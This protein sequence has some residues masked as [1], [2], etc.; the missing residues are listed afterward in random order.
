MMSNRNPLCEGARRANLTVSYPNTPDI[1]MTETSQRESSNLSSF[2][3]FISK[4]V[5]SGAT[6]GSKCPSTHD[7][8]DVD[9]VDG[10]PPSPFVRTLSGVKYGD[11][12]TKQSLD[13]YY[14]EDY[15]SRHLGVRDE[16]KD[17][18][19]KRDDGSEHPSQLP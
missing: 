7:V 13:L 3:A 17:G 19:D 15:A 2:S 4:L 8:D 1:L 11:E 5:S 9:D 14:P 12:S 18:T 6:W 16:T 10:I